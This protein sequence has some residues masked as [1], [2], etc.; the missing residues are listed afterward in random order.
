MLTSTEPC[1]A[2]GESLQD[3]LKSSTKVTILITQ[4]IFSK[5]SCVSGKSKPEGPDIAAGSQTGRDPEVL[6]ATVTYNNI[7]CSSPE[8]VQPYA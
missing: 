2:G 5:H 1:T 6:Y 3:D 8:K 7:T 4:G